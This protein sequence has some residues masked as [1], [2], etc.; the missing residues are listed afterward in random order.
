VGWLI[1][2]SHLYFNRTTKPHLPRKKSLSK[3][4][5]MIEGLLRHCTEMEIKKNY[6]AY[7]NL[8]PILTR[9]INWDLIRQQYEQMVK[10]ATALRLGTAETEA[11]L[12]RFNRNSLKHYT[13]SMKLSNRS[14][15]FIPA[16]TL[17]VLG[18]VGCGESKGDQCKRLTQAVQESREALQT[19]IKLQKFDVPTLGQVTQIYDN[20]AQRIANLSSFSDSGVHN[21]Q[22]QS[23]DLYREYTAA[24]RD[25]LEAYDR[26]KQGKGTDSDKAKSALY[27]LQQAVDRERTLKA[28]MKDY[29]P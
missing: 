2:F 11:I 8:Q 3:V 5:A 19:I 10:Y 21:L 18:L 7:P 13:T 29:C 17:L 12:K 24:G 14:I 25:L 15:I 6:N 9:P 27:R 26:E 16:S 4:A 20:S 23:I 28:Q 1:A 22:F